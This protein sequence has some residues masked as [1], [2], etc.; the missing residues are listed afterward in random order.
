M[1]HPHTRWQGKLRETGKLICT[2]VY[3][4]SLPEHLLCQLSLGKKRESRNCRAISRLHDFAVSGGAI[5]ATRSPKS[6]SRRDPVVTVGP[7]RVPSLAI[8]DAAAVASH[9]I[10]KI[11]ELLVAY[12]LRYVRRSDFFPDSR[13]SVS[14]VRRTV[15]VVSRTG[16]PRNY[17]VGSIEREIFD[18]DRINRFSLPSVDINERRATAKK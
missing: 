4:Q 1:L 17:R 13:F 9:P 6:P 2:L 10:N 11:N 5:A 7:R 8:D 16:F 15:I 14:C 3:R 12:A 18:S